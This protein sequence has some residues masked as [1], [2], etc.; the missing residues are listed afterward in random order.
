[1]RRAFVAVL[2]APVL[3]G[4]QEP[5]GNLKLPAAALE[6]A[7]KGPLP[8]AAILATRH[9]PMS[10]VT[11]DDPS[12]VPPAAVA[13]D[14]PLTTTL[15]DVLARLRSAHP[16]LTVTVTDGVVGV[17][18]PGLACTE[19]IGAPALKPTSMSADMARLLIFLSW[20][21][22]GAQPPMPAGQVSVLG[23]KQGDPLPQPPPMD[24]IT[25]S[26][27]TNSTL[28]ANF[29]D[30]V[31][32]NRGGVWIVWQYVRSDGATVCR[33]VGYYSNGAV[34]AAMK[35]FAVIAR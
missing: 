31:R 30:V 9:V 1:M 5:L 10:I 15:D 17:R 29:D 27:K 19:R 6:A 3:V 16:E 23:G 28:A 12:A 11:T 32:L 35:D 25:L 33:S 24:S 22:S 14:A 34:G 20:W 18:T 26:V 7:G 13:A 21:A 4:V 8:L 2:L